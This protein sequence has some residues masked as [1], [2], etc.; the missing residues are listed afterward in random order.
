MSVGHKEWNGGHIDYMWDKM[1][2]M[3]NKGNRGKEEWGRLEH[4]SI[5][6]LFEMS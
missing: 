3:W 5:N 2:I 6:L 1:D 4:R